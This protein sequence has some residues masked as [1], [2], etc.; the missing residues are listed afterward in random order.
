M[1]SD[2]HHSRALATRD[3][4]AGLQQ[5]GTVDWTRFASSVVNFT[6]ELLVRLSNG[7]VEGLTVFA[8]ETVLARL[9]LGP[10]GEKRT[11]NAVSRLKAF[12]SFSNALWFGFGAKHV[13]RALAES[14]EGLSCIATCSALLEF[15]STEDAAKILRELLVSCDAPGRLT[16]SLSQWISLVELCGGAFATTEF[17]SLIHE[18][19]RLNLPDG[20]SELR[21][22][23]E[24]RFIAN[25]LNKLIA[26]SNGSL[27]RVQFLGGADCGWLAAFA[28]W[29]LDLPA[30]V[31]D[32]A[33][34]VRYRSHPESTDP[35][36][37]VTYDNESDSVQ[38]VKTATIVKSGE[39]FKHEHNRLGYLSEQSTRP[40]DVLSYGRVPWESLLGDTFGR[41]FLDLL[42]G[43]LTTSFG[44]ALG[45][46]ARIFTSVVTDWDEI[47]RN[48]YHLYRKHWKYISSSSHGRGFVNI[49][50]HRL[51]ELAASD[52][53]L[54]AMERGLEASYVDAVA[55]YEQSMQL[56]RASCRCSIC[57]TEEDIRS[58]ARK[59]SSTRFCQFVLI[60]T[61]SRLVQILSSIMPPILVL[62]A[63]AGLE[64]LYWSHTRGFKKRFNYLDHLLSQQ[65]GNNV[66]ESAK[67]LFT[68]RE[69]RR[70][71]GVATSRS[72]LTSNSAVASNGLCFFYHLLV[73]VS[74]NQDQ[75]AALHVIPGRIEWDGNVY[76]E[77]TALPEEERDASK[78]QYQASIGRIMPSTACAELQPSASPDLAYNMLLE[79]SVDSGLKAL[80][81]AY[82][83]ERPDGRR[84]ILGPAHL[85]SELCAAISGKDCGGG[86]CGP[87]PR[88]DVLPVSGEG[89][90]LDH[91]GG[92]GNGLPG[93]E[94]VPLVVALPASPAAQLVA[95]SHAQT[96][97]GPDYVSQHS[98]FV[99][100]LLQDRECLSC[101]LARAAP[102]PRNIRT[103]FLCIITS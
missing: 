23:S 85:T 33:G 39:I 35:K 60:N 64:N 7:G 100:P 46:M 17:G 68:G 41:P 87:V 36:I 44:V 15:Y 98:T 74:A 80:G 38:L 45:C 30:V 84:F 54:D 75:C 77:V 37:L 32:G 67:A 56:I 4:S 48:A 42:D 83:C 79:E 8:A 18:L 96:V 47:D 5:Q 92:G 95:L 88:F 21:Y 72:T 70:G 82:R 76:G 19:T 57:S 6:V 49:I 69:R 1:S 102:G 2:H 10:E 31:Q 73:D 26:I 94:A 86:T 50:R 93:I 58:E 34:R 103:R 12:S 62:P 16:P 13:V 25:A 27:E 101:L 97:A 43:G 63:R 66:L 20:R 91:G 90:V 89:V 11:L 28:I 78:P 29:L 52:R 55:M 40:G 99:V 14:S 22:R 65:E 9:K 61:I 53:L 24:P 71:M 81:L 59:P 51:P 3:N